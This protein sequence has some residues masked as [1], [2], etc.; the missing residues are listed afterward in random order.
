MKTFS[1]KEFKIA[2]QKKI[3]FLMNFALLAGFFGSGATIRIGR[4][5]DFYISLYK[6]FLLSGEA[7]W[8]RVRYQWGLPRLGYKCLYLV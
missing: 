5:R 6:F 7:S 2:A 3:V 1:H 4:V 8:W